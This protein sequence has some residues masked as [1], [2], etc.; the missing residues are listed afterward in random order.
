MSSD[1]E[2]E[3][4]CDGLTEE[5]INALAKINGLKVTSRTSSFFFKN[6]D[7]SVAKIGIGL[8]VST[9]IEG[10]VRLS[11]NT[12]RVT[13]QLIEVQ[14]TESAVG[15]AR[16]SANI[17]GAA[18]G[19]D[20]FTVILTNEAHVFP[21]ANDGTVLDYGDGGTDVEVL[22]GGTNLTPVITTPTS[23]EFSAS[24]SQSNNI[25]ADLIGAPFGVYKRYEDPSGMLQSNNSASIVY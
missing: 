20:G 8:N 18:P 1:K 25:T 24:V 7:I 14:V 19:Q 22:Y 12:I 23:G 17:F 3:Y 5:I 9:I 2:N 4:F 13:A 15:V 21:A 10:S 16:D 6:K 11:N